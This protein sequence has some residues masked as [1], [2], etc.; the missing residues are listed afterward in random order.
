ML[1]YIDVLDRDRENMDE[2]DV[3]RSHL[4][5]DTVQAMTRPKFTGQKWLRIHFLLEEAVDDGGPRRELFRL[6]LQ[7][8]CYSNLFVGLLHSRTVS[9]GVPAL[10]QKKY[11]VAGKTCVL[12]QI[13]FV[14]NMIMSFPGRLMAMSLIQGDPLQSFLHHLQPGIWLMDWKD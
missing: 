11:L 10:Q 2:I 8:C 7:E 9:L 12:T 14:C 3:R 5:L 1:P 4:W 13:D 6:A